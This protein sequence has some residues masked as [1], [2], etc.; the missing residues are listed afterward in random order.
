MDEGRAETVKIPPSMVPNFFVIG[1]GSTFAHKGQFAK[2]GKFQTSF[3]FEAQQERWE[4]DE[5]IR[6]S[7]G[8]D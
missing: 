1:R 5:T 8:G 7:A 6:G 2:L 4:S 3:R